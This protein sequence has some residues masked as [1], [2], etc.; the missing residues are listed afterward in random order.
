MYAMDGSD[1]FTFSSG[2]LTVGGFHPSGSSAGWSDEGAASGIS[3]VG[4]E[5]N[6][7]FYSVEN[8]THIGGPSGP[9]TQPYVAET[10]GVMGCW[11]SVTIPLANNTSDSVEPHVWN[12]S[13]L[14]GSHR[15]VP[16]TPGAQYSFDTSFHDDGTGN[17]SPVYWDICGDK[18][19]HILNL[20]SVA[21]VPITVSAIYNGH[22]I[23]TIGFDSWFSGIDG[24]PTASYSVPGGVLWILAPVGPSSGVISYGSSLPALLAFEQGSC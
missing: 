9:C 4:E 6:W 15:C 3:A 8:V 23:S 12:G 10:P 24:R 18:G 14:I 19:E 1:N 17:Y 21:N 20:T 5:V 22:E 13:G 11:A 16:T 7:T 2:S